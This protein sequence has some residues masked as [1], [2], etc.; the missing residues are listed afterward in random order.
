MNRSD[1]IKSVVGVLGFLFGLYN[2]VA[3]RYGWAVIQFDSVA[4][5]TAINTIITLVFGA[6]STWKNC[7]LT[8][9][10]KDLQAFKDA[11]KNKDLNAIKDTFETIKGMKESLEAELTK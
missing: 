1:V 10:A 5:T 11:V 9:V 6:Y 7:N 8:P 2:V 4:L 3:A